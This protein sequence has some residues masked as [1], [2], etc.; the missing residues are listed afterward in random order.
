MLLILSVI[1]SRIIVELFKDV[2][3]QQLP[4]EG[5]TTWSFVSSAY[6][7][8]CQ[9]IY[10]E[11]THRLRLQFNGGVSRGVRP[12]QYDQID[13]FR[14][15]DVDGNRLPRSN[16]LGLA[17]LGSMYSSND[18]FAVD[19]DNFLD[20]CLFLDGQLESM[21]QKFFFICDET[22]EIYPPKGTKYGPC[23]SSVHDVSFEVA[24]PI[25]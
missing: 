7:N 9:H 11:T 19:G 22:T 15:T 25:L 5:E 24:S 8:H 20:V 4:V 2:E 16:I 13:F 1:I 6:P 12:I 14:I 21:I 23:K 17:D 3:L 10:P 18:M